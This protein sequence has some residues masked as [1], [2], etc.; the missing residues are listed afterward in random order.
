[1]SG[2]IDQELAGYGIRRGD[3]PFLSKPFEQKVFVDL[4]RKTLQELPPSVENLT[5]LLDVG[6]FIVAGCQCKFRRQER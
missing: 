3:L 4:V 2:N 5:A 1:M 6:E